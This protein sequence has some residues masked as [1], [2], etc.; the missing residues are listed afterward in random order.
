MNRK[1]L[2]VED[3]PGIVDAYRIILGS[4]SAPAR[5]VSSRSQAVAVQNA[6][7]AAAFELEVATTGEEALVKIQQA[8]AAGQP[9]AGGFFDVKLGSGIDG[10]ETIRRA[11]DTD[12]EMLYC[13]VTAYQDRSLDEI[14]KVFGP[15]FSDRWDFLA[16]PFTQNEI[17]QKARNLCSSWDRR[18]KEKLYLDQIHTQQDQLV[19]SERLAAIGTLARGIG[20]E[21][22]NILHRLIGI[23]EIA[24]LKNDPTEMR[25]ALS[26]VAT[27]AERAG[28]IVRNLQSLVKM[29]VKRE[30]ISLYTPLKECLTLIDHELKRAGIEVKENWDPELPLVLANKVEI[31]QVFLNLL[32]NAQ[33]AMETTGGTIEI[34]SRTQGK[35]IVVEVADTGCGIAPEHLKR[36]FEPLFTTKGER[37]TGIGLSVCRKIIANHSGRIEVES[38]LGKGSCF[39]LVLPTT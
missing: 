2:I 19:K 3:E 24:A 8:V 31:G 21:F 29:E 15:D 39:R 14:E 4:T 13:L 26:T 33:H 7:V 37:G 6:P 18:Q 12:P 20:H 32:I 17:L 10:I 9:Y 23:S 35:E 36:L 16:K 25:Q 5:I 11:K 28:A 30:K 34:R 27:A 38:T 1:L 22:G